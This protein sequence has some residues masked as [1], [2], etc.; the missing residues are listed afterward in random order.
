MSIAVMETSEK[1]C[2]TKFQQ[3]STC[4]A[5][6]MINLSAKERRRG[7]GAALQHLIA[8]QETLKDERYMLGYLASFRR[9]CR[10]CRHVQ[11]LN[12]LL[13]CKYVVAQDLSLCLF[14]KQQV[15]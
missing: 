2:T 6:A 14:N 11:M 15:Q 8:G 1:E 7:R 10:T 4:A 3:G 9:F 12:T 13:L 5:C